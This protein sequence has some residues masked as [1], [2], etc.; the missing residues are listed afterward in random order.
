[1]QR[2]RIARSGH[3]NPLGWVG[4][5]HRVDAPDLLEETTLCGG[6]V[7]SPQQ[8]KARVDSFGGNT[9]EDGTMGIELLSDGVFNDEL[10]YGAVWLALVVG[11]VFFASAGCDM[12]EGGFTI[13][14]FVVLSWDI[15]G[16]VWVCEEWE[17]LF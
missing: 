3:D 8:F 15:D 14:G 9:D 12:T 11:F 4:A 6:V 2:L 16:L 7:V 17:G 10:L 13:F 1:L 5:H